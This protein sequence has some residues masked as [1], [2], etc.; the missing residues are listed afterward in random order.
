MKEAQIYFLECNGRIKIG[1]AAHVEKRM[2][3]IKRS[4][5]SPVT[6]IASI[7]GDL[8][9]E[10]A[11]HKKLQPYCISGEWYRDCPEV[12]AAIQNCLNHFDLSS[13]EVKKSILTD[14]AKMLWP[15]NTAPNIA[16]EVKCSVRSAERWLAGERDWSSDAVAV[17]VEEMLRR[18]RLRNVKIV[19][20]Q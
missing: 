18:H 2:R 15:R 19:P 10:R 6:L 5:A 1:I 16:A 4:A 3:E 8:K 20:R 9:L 12:R 13:D 7:K 17:V 11:I 14:V